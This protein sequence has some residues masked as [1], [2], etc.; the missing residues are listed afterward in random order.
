MHMKAAPLVGVALFAVARFTG[1]A[2][3]EE[4]AHARKS[5]R[6]PCYPKGT[7]TIL[8]ND[9]GRIYRDG[10]RESYN[11]LACRYRDSREHF[12]GLTPPPERRCPA[13]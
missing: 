7:K 9:L 13:Q 8:A 10:K 11:V 4:T 5:A 1:L 2:A 3:S 6:P 12:L